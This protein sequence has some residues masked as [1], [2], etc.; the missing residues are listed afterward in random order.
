MAGKF[1]IGCKVSD[2]G[3][4]GAL[5]LICVAKRREKERQKNLHRY[6]YKDNHVIND[7]IIASFCDICK[8]CIGLLTYFKIVLQE[9]L[10]KCR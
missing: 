10:T 7:S 8:Y 6:D 5:C 3:T 2:V 9:D 1:C 4:S